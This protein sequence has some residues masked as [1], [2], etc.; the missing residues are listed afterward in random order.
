MGTV[1]L[2]SKTRHTPSSWLLSMQLHHYP[3]RR[4]RL[5]YTLIR[6]R[7]QPIAI[8]EWTTMTRTKGR[9]NNP[10]ILDA[11]KAKYQDSN[12]ALPAPRTGSSSHQQQKPRGIC[13]LCRDRDTPMLPNSQQPLCMPLHFNTQHTFLPV[14]R[15]R[16]QKPQPSRWP[17]TMQVSCMSA[18]R[19]R[20]RQELRRKHHNTIEEAGLQTHHPLN[21]PRTMRRQ[22]DNLT[23]QRQRKCLSLLAHSAAY[24]HCSKRYQLATLARRT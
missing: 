18:N 2:P 22:A 3:R 14:R 4:S 5:V 23:R 11:P 15:A 13:R 12:M 19:C 17:N 6:N 24:R 8:L 20:R 1:Y 16:K 10:I 21:T 9:T 7:G